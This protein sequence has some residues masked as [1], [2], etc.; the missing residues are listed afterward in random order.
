MKTAVIPGFKTP[1]VR[2]FLLKRL[3]ILAYDPEDTREIPREAVKT[4]ELLKAIASKTGV[5]IRASAEE[6]AKTL[7]QA[8]EVPGLVDLLKN[9]LGIVNWKNTLFPD[10]TILLEAKWWIT[11][12]HY[13]ST[14]GAEY[15]GFDIPVYYPGTRADITPEEALAE[16]EQKTRVTPIYRVIRVLPYDQALRELKGYLKQQKVIKPDDLPEFLTIAQKV[17]SDAE[18]PEL[19]SVLLRGLL[20]VEGNRPITTTKAGDVLAALYYILTGTP[21]PTVAMI[22]QDTND[23]AKVGR[24]LDSQDE[25]AL[26]KFF[27]EAYVTPF[28]GG[29]K[30]RVILAK[31][32]EQHYSFARR[33]HNK[34]FRNSAKHARKVR[35]LNKDLLVLLPAHITQLLPEFRGKELPL[36]KLPN[37]VLLRLWHYAKFAITTLDTPFL[38]VGGRTFKLEDDKVHKREHTDAYLELLKLTEHELQERLLNSGFDRLVLR[39]EVGA[40]VDPSFLDKGTVIDLPVGA[41]RVFVG[42][43]WK[44]YPNG[45]RVDLDLSAWIDG[46]VYGWNGSYGEDGIE[47]SGDVTAAPHPYGGAEVIMLTRPHTRKA[48]FTYHNYTGTLP[49][50]VMFGWGYD[51]NKDNKEYPGLKD[52]ELVLPITVPQN[53]NGLFVAGV[54]YRG[55]LFLGGSWKVWLG[56]SLTGKEYFDK[57]GGE[58]IIDYIVAKMITQPTLSKLVPYWEVSED[59]WDIQKTL[60]KLQEFSLN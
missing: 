20:V 34:L 24:Y 19:K 27:E 6:F 38:V 22:K 54:V 5:E 57:F 25:K 2:T 28:V 55:K 9:L 49:E 48:V 37:R 31:L 8:K 47:F 42:I 36:E 32:R 17:L 21:Q 50:T 3:N 41:G 33:I 1:E 46:Q 15:F 44:E 56:N 16:L 60:D 59:G 35:K 45:E 11:L 58:E 29:R 30:A 26:R 39:P 4:A 51:W 23:W 52:F 7:V 13:M 10:G 14:Y 18:I 53:Q 40:Q 12:L 43:Y